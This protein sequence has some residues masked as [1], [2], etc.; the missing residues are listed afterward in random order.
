MQ[1]YP[2]LLGAHRAVHGGLP[3]LHLRV[4]PVQFAGLVPHG[5]HHLPVAAVLASSVASA[6]A[7]RAER[8]H[9]ARCAVC[10]GP[11]LAG[12]A[13]GAV[14]AGPEEAAGSGRLRVCGEEGRRARQRRRSGHGGK[15]RLRLCIPLSVANLT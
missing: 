2:H 1:P 8:L 10:G 7:A 6:A 3:V 9:R 14:R 4:R 15:L 12:Q 13:A 11:D 5:Q